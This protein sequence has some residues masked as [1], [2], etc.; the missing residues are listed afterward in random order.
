[1]SGCNQRE[2]CSLK[3]IVH[4]RQ[5]SAMDMGND[6]IPKGEESILVGMFTLMEMEWRDCKGIVP[7]RADFIMGE[8]FEIH[9]YVEHQH[10]EMQ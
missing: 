4:D 1:M 8:A 9:P 7:L 2:G 5:I 3:R 10:V 6:L